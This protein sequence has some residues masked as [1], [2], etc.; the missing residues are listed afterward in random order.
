MA[1]TFEQLMDDLQKQL[2]ELTWELKGPKD[3]EDYVV[4]RV[5]LAIS[6][7]KQLHRKRT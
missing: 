4:G 2:V 6:A 5:V 3:E 1:K 7:L